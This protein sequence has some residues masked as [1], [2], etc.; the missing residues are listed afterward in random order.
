MKVRACWSALEN[1]AEQAITQVRAET[2]QAEKLR[3]SME[4][5]LRQD[6]HADEDEA[7]CRTDLRVLMEL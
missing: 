3:E 1:K 5:Y 4:R 7:R 6:M 2:V